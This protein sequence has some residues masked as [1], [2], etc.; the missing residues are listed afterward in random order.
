VKTLKRLTYL[1]IIKLDE[2]LYARFPNLACS[3]RWVGML[4]TAGDNLWPG[5]DGENTLA[6]AL[7]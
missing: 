4:E 2:A 6:E 5:H 7:R 3:P 1:V